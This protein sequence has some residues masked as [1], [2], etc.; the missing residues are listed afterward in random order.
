MERGLG[1]AEGSPIG[2]LVQAGEVLPCG[3]RPPTQ[4]QMGLWGSLGG[5]D[6]VYC[7]VSFSLIFLF[8]LLWPPSPANGWVGLGCQQRS[9]QEN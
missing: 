5:V 9:P 1:A 6:S 7:L 2:S 3:S 8:L 4:L